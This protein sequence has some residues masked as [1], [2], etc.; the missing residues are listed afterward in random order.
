MFDPNAVA[1]LSSDPLNEDE[2][3]TV[4]AVAL[5]LG[6]VPEDDDYDDGG[7]TNLRLFTARLTGAQLRRLRAWLNYYGTGIAPGRVKLSGGDDGI[8]YSD[9]EEQ[10][11]PEEE[12]MLIV[13]KTKYPVD[14]QGL[15]AF[16]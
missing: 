1:L 13:F 16:S 3:E 6:F 14:E 4:R 10:Y 15:P 7:L 9:E 8:E 11:Q 12:M 2:E 5:R